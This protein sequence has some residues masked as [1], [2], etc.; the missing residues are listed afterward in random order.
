MTLS[1]EIAEAWINILALR[2]Q[3]R[4]I[5]RQLK[6]NEQILDLLRFRFMNSLATALDVLQQEETVAGSKAA[7]P[8]LRAR[9]NVLLNQLA[10][11]VGKMP[12]QIRVEGDDLPHVPPVPKTGLPADLLALRPD[13]RAAGLRLEAADWSVAAARADRLPALR[14]TARG[15]FF[16]EQAG[17]IFQNWLADLTAS[18]TGPLFDAGRRRAE[19]ERSRAVVRERLAAYESVVAQALSEVQ[20]ALSS[21]YMQTETISSLRTQLQAAGKSHTQAEFR[22]RNGLVEYN[23]VLTELLNVQ[24][25]E[26]QM[27]QARAEL[28]LERVRL[29]RALGGS[30]T[31]DIL[32]SRA[33]FENQESALCTMRRIYG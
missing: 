17:N 5:E 6:V 10:V 24:R 33:A 21:G 27:V 30:W 15:E 32:S 11:L 4:V 18:V 19:V 28:L 14:L 9:E 25:L 16:A 20:N 13:I 8:D 22:Y 7:L 12:G 1:G 29:G 31:L 26:Q 3:R 23:V 2:E